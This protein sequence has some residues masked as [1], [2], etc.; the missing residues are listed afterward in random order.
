VAVLARKIARAKWEAVGNLDVNEIAAPKG[1]ADFEAICECYSSIGEKTTLEEMT[2][3]ALA[4]Y[5]SY[6]QHERDAGHAL[7]WAIC[8]SLMEKQ[9]NGTLD[10]TE[11][12]LLIK[13]SV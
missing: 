13:V 11:R 8:Q 6:K 2:D 7:R 1:S 3:L 9:R 12:E 10:Q 4:L 5:D